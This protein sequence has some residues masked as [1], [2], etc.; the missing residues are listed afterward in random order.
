MRFADYGGETRPRNSFPDPAVS[1]CQSGLFNPRILRDGFLGSG[2][3]L[4]VRAA[5]QDASR[6]SVS[7]GVAGDAHTSANRVGSR[8]RNSNYNLEAVMSEMS[9]TT[10]R[11]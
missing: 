2:K 6:S 5:V 1:R 7:A 8:V 9:F 10:D 11:A 4:A 3:K